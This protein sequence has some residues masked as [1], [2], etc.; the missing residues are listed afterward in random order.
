MTFDDRV[1][2][3]T[4]AS[5]GIGEAL[6]YACSRRGARLLL[7]ARRAG[8]LEAVRQRCAHPERHHVVPLDLACPASLDAAAA[9]ALAVHGRVDVLVNNGGIS[10]RALARELRMDVVRRV[11]EVNFFST[12]ALTQAVLPGMRARGEGHLVVVSSVTGKISTPGR[13]AYAAS[14]FALHGYFDALRAEEAAAG[15]RVTVACPGYVRTQVSVNAVTADGSP[16]GQMD[17]NQARAMPA[18]AC[19]ARIVRAVE[20][21]RAE[22]LMG[23][24]EVWGVLLYRL[25]PGLYRRL[26]AR[27]DFTPRR[28]DEG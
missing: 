24:A 7:S 14:K 15:I 13:S 8:A 11:L 22:V 4:G 25:A 28:A 6:A 12:V 9:A 26:L 10:Q 17:A 16:H 19:A 21:E 18:A 27:L 20:R 3:I 5:S 1:V 2:W 23:G